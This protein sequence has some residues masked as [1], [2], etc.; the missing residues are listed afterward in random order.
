MIAWFARNG[1]A[2]NLLMMGILI[3]GTVTLFTGIPTEVF[4]EF[5]LDLVNVS[6][7]YRGSTPAE[8]EE[9]VVIR[10]EEAIQDLQ[11][12]KKILSTASEGMG[13]VR[14]EVDKGYDS[15]EVLDDIKN[16]VDA[17]NTFP[18]E[19]EKP[20]ISLVQPRG[21][22]ITA[23]L[24]ADM[25]EHDLRLL[26]E[27]IRDEI[28]N[29]PDIT[30]VGLGGVRPYEIA[31]EVSEKTLQQYGLTLTAVANAIRRTSVDLPAGVIKSSGG[32]ILLRTK[33]Q[34]YVGQEFADIVLITRP[35]GSRIT[36]GDIATIKDDFEETPLYARFNGQPC[37]LISVARVGDQNAITLARSVKKFL[38]ERRQS[39][40]PGVEL[41][42]WNDR[43][44]VVINRL[45]TLTSSAWQGGILVLLVLALFLRP[46]V[47]LWVFAGI[48]VAFMGAILFMPSLG[49]TINVISLFAFILVLGIVVDD[50]IVTGENIFTHLQQGEDS[51]EAAITGAQE[52][53]TPVVFGVLTTV[54]AF[55]PLMMIEGFM[56]KIFGQI[57]LIVIPVLLFSL[58]ESKFILPAHLK[59]LSVGKRD[60]GQ[61]NP[62]LRIQR[63]FADGM[64]WFAR[65]VYQPTLEI[66]L[67]RRI[68]TLC[69][70]VGTVAVIFA[71]VASN[72]I[73]FVFFPRVQSERATAALTMAQGTPTEVTARFIRRMEAA[74]RELQA[75]PKYVDPATGRNIIEDI[76]SVVGGQG[77]TGG[78]G[79]GASGQS[80]IGEV[81]LQ[82]TAPEERTLSVSSMDIVNEW[83][84]MIGPVPGAQDLN[85]RAEIGR[86]SS[87]IDVQLSGPDFEDLSAAA[88]LVK[89][90]LAEYPDLFD[91]TDSYQ[92]G[93]PEIKLRIKPEAEALGLTMRDLAQQSREAFFGAEAQRIQRGR[94]DVRV[95]V[96][97]PLEERSSL[98]SLENMRIRTA[99][100]AE[101]PFASVAEVE[102]GRSFSTIN[103]IDRNRT[104][105]V[106]AD[107]DKEKANLELIKRDL[108][109]FL[110]DLVAQY[111]G[112]SFSM[113]GEAREQ[114][115]SFGAVAVGGI[116]VLFAI[117]A[118]LAIPFRSYA[119]P[120]IVMSVIPFGLAGAIV[121]H[122]IMGFSLS[123]MSVFGMLALAGVVVN[124]SLVMVDYINR[125]RSEGMS[126]NEA[127]RVAGVARFRAIM[128]TSLTTFCGLLP[129]MF[130]KSTQA[131]FLIP[132][133]ISLGW[134]VMLAT[135][136]TLLLVPINYL[137]LEDWKAA[138]RRYWAWQT[139][140]DTAPPG[141]ASA[142]P[143]R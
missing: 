1:V 11:G 122:L 120:A 97:Y 10:I 7:P 130:E 141:I 67:R 21:E 139:G 8:V 105:N 46:A 89:E 98:D 24:A 124:D 70:F 22:V 23:V 106:T 116:F 44:Q 45:N 123:I 62:V 73:L 60:R 36:L 95:M 119:Q 47:A 30:Q 81:S 134:G 65:R 109:E 69:L 51:T 137:L 143:A 49:V 59:H 33:G 13:S 53:S 5:Q 18:V 43:S 77:V 14:V 108:T 92:D 12:I 72:R 127:V 87:P 104:V 63:R 32:E 80:H 83:R 4:P 91:I 41:S 101:V 56:G 86:G 9:S 20:V 52:V 55:T 40:P 107:A 126:V 131:Q 128:L 88:D 57:P 38:A 64:E 117:Y 26:G 129:L 118:M 96:R 138:L 35:D 112:M 19:T 76:M 136:V 27:Q 50:A 99:G 28:V 25:S 125:R 84:R 6:V 74:A 94:E 31:I 58:L 39:L 42:Y 115:E 133:G 142:P 100:G 79:R 16:R 3:A 48:P 111:P 113:E 103:R 15:R 54:A 78:R 85:F 110:P 132:M 61:L 114:A 17:I 82:L 90:R 75:D 2:A 37:V 66:A 140:K 121:G 29:L 102:M 68:L 34:A 93:K 135:F 71:F